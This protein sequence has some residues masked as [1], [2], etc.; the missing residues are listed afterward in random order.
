MHF[1]VQST[2]HT[3]CEVYTNRVTKIYWTDTKKEKEKREQYV[4]LII[5]S[6]SI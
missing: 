4:V 3:H 6:L 5:D 1:S 2:V